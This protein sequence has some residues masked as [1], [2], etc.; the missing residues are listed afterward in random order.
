MRTEG[1]MSDGPAA[2]PPILL[3]ST[4]RA[5]STWTRRLLASALDYDSTSVHDPADLD[6]AALSRTVVQLHCLPSEALL[7][8]LAHHDV[9]VV[10]VARH[11]LDVLVSIL[12]F[13]RDATETHR[14]LGGQ[15]G[16]ER[17]IVGCR[18][19]DPAFR[20]YALGD[21]AAALLGV[22]PR[23]WDIDGTVAV[24]YEDLE[25]PDGAD[26]LTR[27][28]EELGSDGRRVA[29][30]LHDSSMSNMAR[31]HPGRDFHFGLGGSGSWRSFLTSDLAQAIHD[32]HHQVFAALGYRVDP[33]P[34]LSPGDAERA[35]LEYLLATLEQRLDRLR[36]PSEGY[37]HL[38]DRLGPE[39]FDALMAGAYDQTLFR[40]AFHVGRLKQEHPVAARALRRVRR[41]PSG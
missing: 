23:W 3:T 36:A 27:V 40:A 5:G 17:T 29:A 24:R 26:H 18:P 39:M 11:P 1:G 38:R 9:R 4:P 35:W 8:D 13:V 41:R 14:W 21:R 22:T 30:A 25:G 6:W 19:T 32:R 33:D 16:D 2:G 28:L 15:A 37:R 12:R 10:S 34:D 31:G 7:Q 20:E